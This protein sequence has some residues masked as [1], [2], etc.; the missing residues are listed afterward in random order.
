M[1]DGMAPRVALKD[2]SSKISRAG[3][4]RGVWKSIAVRCVD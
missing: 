1:R 2:V 3:W 4:I